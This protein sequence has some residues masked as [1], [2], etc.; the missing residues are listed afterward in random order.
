M[1]KLRSLGSVKNG[2]SNS[3]TVFSRHDSVQ[4]QE[5]SRSGNTEGPDRAS[6]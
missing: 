2:D 5:V 3:G 6:K 1:A 4:P